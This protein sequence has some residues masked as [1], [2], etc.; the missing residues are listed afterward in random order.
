MQYI[1]QEWK[2]TQRSGEPFAVAILDMDNFKQINDQWGHLVGD[3]VLRE[4]S[5]MFKGYIRQADVFARYGG[6]EFIFLFPQTDQQQIQ[7]WAD[8]IHASFAGTSIQVDGLE[9]QP[10]FS[11][12]VA[13]F[14]PDMQKVDDLLK[15]ADEALY[16]AKRRGG[17]QFIHSQK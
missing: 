14:D 1:E 6:D 11:M 12:G 10:L 17:N 2:R 15:R 8:R 9:I 4:M 7:T 5:R 16:Q 3:T 13:V